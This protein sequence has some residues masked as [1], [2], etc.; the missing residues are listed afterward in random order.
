MLAVIVIYGY[1]DGN[2]SLGEECKCVCARPELS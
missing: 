2:V 1:F